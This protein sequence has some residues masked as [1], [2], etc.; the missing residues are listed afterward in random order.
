MIFL[1]NKYF[2]PIH[3]LTFAFRWIQL[4]QL[5]HNNSNITFA[6]FIKHS[7]NRKQEEKMS[8]N[9]FIEFEKQLSAQWNGRLICHRQTKASS[10][11]ATSFIQTVLRLY[12]H[13]QTKT[14]LSIYKLKML[15]RVNCEKLLQRYLT[16]VTLACFI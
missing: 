16:L 2:S 5:Y 1:V 15:E 13:V 11:L 12:R 8:N 10:A 6:L 14:S 4:Y 7:A 3:V 9:D